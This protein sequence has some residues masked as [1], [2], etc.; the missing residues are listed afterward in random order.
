MVLIVQARDKYGKKYVRKPRRAIDK[1]PK[2]ERGIVEELDRKR[3]YE[4]LKKYRDELQKKRV[5]VKSI[6]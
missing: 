1:L 4:R 3:K 2:N 5:T 6:G